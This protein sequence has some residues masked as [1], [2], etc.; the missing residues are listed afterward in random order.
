[1]PSQKCDQEP[2]SVTVMSL[3]S[4]FNIRINKFFGEENNDI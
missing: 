1:M 2:F 4:I 3:I